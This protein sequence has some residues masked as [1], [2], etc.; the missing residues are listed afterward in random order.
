MKKNKTLFLQHAF[1]TTTV[2]E[3]EN[4]L[5]PDVRIKLGRNQN[6]KSNEEKKEFEMCEK[7]LMNVKSKAM[8]DNELDCREAFMTSTLAEYLE[9]LSTKSQFQIGD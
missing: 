3:A 9:S 1:L 5:V 6:K 4:W 2:A 8:T 7:L